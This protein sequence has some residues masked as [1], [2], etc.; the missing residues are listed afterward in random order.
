MCWDTAV[1][2]LPGYISF[3]QGQNTVHCW[4]RCIWSYKKTPPEATIRH[5]SYYVAGWYRN[6][7]RINLRIEVY[8]IN[9][10][11]SIAWQAK[12]WLCYQNAGKCQASEPSYEGMVNN[13]ALEQSL[14][15]SVKTDLIRP[16]LLQP[17][18]NLSKCLHHF[19]PSEDAGILQHNTKYVAGCGCLYGQGKRFW[20][21]MR[22]SASDR[23]ESACHTEKLLMRCL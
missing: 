17:F 18:F 7:Y 2:R 22:A 13:S 4:S 10:R 19:I 1:W 21:S 16:Y 15:S 6:A 14:F 9:L 5:N 20:K 23:E 3:P 11:K 8:Y 12:R